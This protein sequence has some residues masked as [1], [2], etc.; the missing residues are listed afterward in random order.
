MDEMLQALREEYAGTPLHEQDIDPDPVAQFRRWFDDAVR[1]QMPLA[2][3]MTLAT[4][5]ARGRPSARVVLLKQ[6]DER[7]FVFFT[8]YESRKGRELSENPEAALVFWWPALHRQVRVE[9]R[10]ERLEAEP[11]DRYFRERPY[12]SNLSAAASPQSRPVASREEL[13]RRVEALRAAHPEG[14]LERPASWGGYRLVPRALELWQGREDRLHDRL[15]YELDDGRWR[16][17]RLAP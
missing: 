1:A 2:N 17:A 7:G 13:E 11:S 3:G 8:N 14:S 10:V 15:R 16:V 12:P 9:G 4:V 5:D 6:A